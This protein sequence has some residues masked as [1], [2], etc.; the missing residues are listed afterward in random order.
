MK[1]DCK[2][3]HSPNEIP[4]D[5]SICILR[6]DGDD[7]MVSAYD[8]GEKSFYVN[9]GGC[10]FVT[11]WDIVKGWACLEDCIFIEE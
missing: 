5:G 8:E 6:L 7:V 3:W 2:N 1:V 11:E 10:G 4:K 9:F